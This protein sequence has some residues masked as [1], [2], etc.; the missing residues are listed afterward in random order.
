MGI[1]SNEDL[2]KRLKESMEYTDY[3][4]RTLRGYDTDRDWETFK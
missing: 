3:L 2:F 4:Y 1:K